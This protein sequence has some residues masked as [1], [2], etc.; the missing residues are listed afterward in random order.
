MHGKFRI[1]LRYCCHKL[2]VRLFSKPL[3]YVTLLTIIIYSLKGSTDKARLLS[4]SV[5]TGIDTIK[6]LCRLTPLKG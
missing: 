3:D 6:L 2:A 4:E 1:S 5:S